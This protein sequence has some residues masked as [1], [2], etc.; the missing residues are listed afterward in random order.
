MC[1]AQTQSLIVH[2]VSVVHTGIFKHLLVTTFFC[3]VRRITQVVAIQL[4]QTS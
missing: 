4:V 3:Y 2:A 1:K